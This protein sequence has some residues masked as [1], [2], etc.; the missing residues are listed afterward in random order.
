MVTIE[1]IA[2]ITEDGVITAKAPASAPRGKHRAVI[3]LEDAPMEKERP[4][5]GFPNLTS[6][7]FHNYQ[8]RVGC[9]SEIK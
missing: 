4:A 8:K 7:K 2:T 6:R 3:I 9:Q 5:E 1:T